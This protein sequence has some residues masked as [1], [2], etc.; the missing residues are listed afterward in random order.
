MDKSAQLARMRWHCRRGMLEL[1][2]I[3]LPFFDQAFNKLSESD[4]A[5]F[6]S[7]L[8]EE[9]TDLFVWL[10][11]QEQPSDPDCLHIITLIRNHIKSKA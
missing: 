6:E 4:Q 3:L 1:D 5:L 8:D 9:D 11:G 10:L 2:M 7:L